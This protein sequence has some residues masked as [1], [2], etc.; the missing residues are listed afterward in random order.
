[1]PPYLSVAL[2]SLRACVVTASTVLVPSTLSAPAADAR[3][4]GHSLAL[5]GTTA[6]YMPTLELDSGVGH[7]PE[8]QSPR[9]LPRGGEHASDGHQQPQAPSCRPSPP[10]QRGNWHKTS[11]AFRNP[12]CG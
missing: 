7:P 1:M 12:P 3:T 4:V 9:G 6:Y 5:N 11:N 2:A 10:C 8:P